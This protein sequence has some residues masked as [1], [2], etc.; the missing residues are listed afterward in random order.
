VGV[1]GVLAKKAGVIDGLATPS[2][3]PRTARNP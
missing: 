1:L 2:T 3:T